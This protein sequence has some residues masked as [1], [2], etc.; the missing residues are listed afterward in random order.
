MVVWGAK[1]D[2]IG[3]SHSIQGEC[4]FLIKSETGWDG[5]DVYSIYME[6]KTSDGISK[7][8]MKYTLLL[9]IYELKNKIVISMP[10][11]HPGGHAQV[12]SGST[13]SEHVTYDPTL[14]KF[15][16]EFNIEN[17]PPQ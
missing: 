14:E 13:W 2:T 3:K 1:Y 15:G 9:L 12:M 4:K 7:N 16:V 10:D 17:T 5:R 11:D 6:W 8:T